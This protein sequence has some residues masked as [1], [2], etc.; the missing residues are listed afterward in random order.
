MSFESYDFEDSAG[1]ILRRG[2]ILNVNKNK[3]YTIAIDTGVTVEGYPIYYGGASDYNVDDMSYNNV[4]NPSFFPHYKPNDNVLCLFMTIGQS[5]TSNA[6][7]LGKVAR[8]KQEAYFVHPDMNQDDFFLRSPS[9]AGI[10]L[11]HVWNGESNIEDLNDQEYPNANGNITYIANRSVFLSGEKYL[12]FGLYVSNEDLFKTNTLRG[13]SGVPSNIAY[14]PP[15]IN[16]GEMLL[17]HQ[18]GQKLYMKT[19]GT[20]Q[21]SSKGLRININDEDE[22][23]FYNKD[24]QSSAQDSEDITTKTAV[25]KFKETTF[26]LN[27]AGW[28]YIIDDNTYLKFLNGNVEVS[29]NLLVKG[30]LTVEGDVA[31][32]GKVV[33]AGGGE[34]G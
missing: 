27:E 24:H 26:T 9:G 20:T 34:F 8:T 33:A 12:P 10:Y 28:T 31:V 18:T 4:P 29:G 3:M 1:V 21:L 23:I 11:N 5:I 16:D 22:T 15:E 7:I 6:F 17:I 2:T 13:R 14:T 32:T 19:D 25:I 30:N